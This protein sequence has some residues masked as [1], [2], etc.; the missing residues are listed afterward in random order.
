LTCGQDIEGGGQRFQKGTKRLPTAPFLSFGPG[1]G[2]REREGERDPGQLFLRRTPKSAQEADAAT[3][4]ISQTQRILLN[5][6]EMVISK[7]L[8]VLPRSSRR[9]NSYKLKEKLKKGEKGNSG[10]G[11]GKKSAGRKAGDE[12]WTV[13]S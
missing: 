9:T 5:R 7:R 11:G 8:S 6:E 4:T 2:G 10:D 12:G 3:N 1:G 13:K